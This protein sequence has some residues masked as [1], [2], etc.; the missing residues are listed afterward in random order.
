MAYICSRCY[1]APELIFGSTDYT[2]Q[3]D[4]WSVGCVIVEMI[5]GEPPFVGGSQLDQLIEIMRV[6]G[7][8]N[9]DEV[10]EMNKE[11]DM[12]N[13][14]FPTITRKEWKKVNIILFSF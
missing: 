10:L 1:R 3:V 12:K 4:M 9:K 6:L 8:P 14:R 5:N 7:T 11:Y 2:T 13:Y